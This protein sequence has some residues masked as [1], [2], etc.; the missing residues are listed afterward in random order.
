MTKQYSR[1][2]R[3]TRSTT[4][5]NGSKSSYGLQLDRWIAPERIER[6]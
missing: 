3:Y 6:S 1:W 2:N 5:P 4:A